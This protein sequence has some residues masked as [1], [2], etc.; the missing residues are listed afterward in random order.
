MLNCNKKLKIK[1][2]KKLCCVRQKKIAKRFI[3]KTYSLD[4]E[5]I[6]R[7]CGFFA[8]RGFV[9]NAVFVGNTRCIVGDNWYKNRIKI[10]SSIMVVLILVWYLVMSNVLEKQLIQIK[11]NH[12]L[13][14]TLD[15]KEGKREEWY[16]QIG[17]NNLAY[18]T[19]IEK[20]ILLPAGIDKLVVGNAEIYFKG[21]FAKE[22]LSNFKMALRE[23]TRVFDEKKIT[24]LPA[25]NKMFMCEL[26]GR[27]GK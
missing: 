25:S 24:V 17:K 11:K 6:K 9:I 16:E 21:Y 14:D 5:I 8:T 23:L 10:V 22:S 2:S 7:V 13:F 3:W 26:R 27:I 12:Q 1:F 18:L 4:E 19:L 15:N 20:F